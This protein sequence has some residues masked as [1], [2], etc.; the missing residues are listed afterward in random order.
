[1][2]A[3][4]SLIFCAGSFSA[5]HRRTS[6]ARSI[7]AHR[8]WAGSCKSPCPDIT[9]LFLRRGDFIPCPGSVSDLLKMRWFAHRGESLE[10]ATL[11][12]RKKKIHKIRCQP[13]LQETSARW[14]GASRRHRRPAA[15]R[16]AGKPSRLPEPLSCRILAAQ[17]L[18]Y[19]ARQP[20]AGRAS[21][22]LSG[23]CCTSCSASSRDARQDRRRPRPSQSHPDHPGSRLPRHPAAPLRSLAAGNELPTGLICPVGLPPLDVPPRG[24]GVIT[25]GVT[26]RSGHPERFAPMQVSDSP[27]CSLTAKRREPREGRASVRLTWAVGL[28]ARRP[29][30]L[31]VKHRRSGEGC[32]R[33]CPRRMRV[34]GR[35][36][37]SR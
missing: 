33:T 15:P 32:G 27:C 13:G 36:A 17:P 4:T 30:A 21:L 20:S 6:W 37:P 5:Y 24:N 19:A 22:P 3:S 9:T 35:G 7:C 23:H 16:S 12:Q 18:V 29:Q 11:G 28:G 34:P 2:K 8:V 1:M 10:L 26:M 31:G 14:P 25:T